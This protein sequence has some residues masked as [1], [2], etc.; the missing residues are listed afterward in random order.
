MVNIIVF[1]EAPCKMSFSCH[2]YLYNV[3][4]MQVQ[5]KCDVIGDDVIGCKGDFSVEASQV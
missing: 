5:V 1:T 2:I 4:V 3:K